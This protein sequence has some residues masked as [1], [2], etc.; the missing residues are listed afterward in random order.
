[1][2]EMVQLELLAPARDL[3]CGMA[4]INCGADAVYIGAPKFGARSA[5]GNSLDNLAKLVNYAHKYSARVYTTVNTI[6]YDNELEDARSLIIT[7]HDAGIDA[8]IIQDMA[9][10]EMDLPPVPLFASTQ[11]DNRLPEKIKFLEQAGI[12]RVILARE[13]SL[14]QIKKIRTAANVELEAFIHGALCVSY[15]G[16]CYISHAVSSRSANR[17]ECIQA[18]RMQYS[19][20]DS[21]NKTVI[22][23]KYLLSL[24]DLNQTDHLS[25]LIDAGIT[26]FKIEGRLKDITY[27]KNITAWYRRKLDDIIESRPGFKKSSSGR[28]EIDFE[29]DPEKTFNRGY[30]SYFIKSGGKDIASFNTQKS[31]G[32]YL[33]RVRHLKDNSFE[34]D[35]PVSLN[36]GDGICFLNQN[37][38]LQGMYVNKTEKGRIYVRELRGLTEGAGIYRNFN[39]QF[40]KELNRDN[41]KRQIAARITVTENNENYILTA[42]DEDG[43]KAEYIFAHGGIPAE[44]MEKMKET[45]VKQ[46]SRSGD[47]L[48][49]INEVVL[50]VNNIYFIRTSV[51]N[52]ARRTLLKD[53]EGERIKNYKP[54]RIKREKTDHKFPAENLTYL[55]NSVNRLSETFYK[56]HGVEK[57][58]KGFELMNSRAGTV[59][60]KCKYCIKKELDI[61]PKDHKGRELN[62]WLEPLYITDNKNKFQ[63]VFDCARCE[64][65]VLYPEKIRK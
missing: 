47:S 11:T 53:L 60:M 33:G 17:G 58:D 51:L 42:E 4:A 34:L 21:L 41:A 20:V 39:H 30:T 49:F 15:S 25:D 6:L 13:L 56:N 52:E 62:D 2:N 29:P 10:L 12:S 5:A 31:T 46:L 1:M 8:V 16:Q 19:L 64:M 65:S 3:E 61:C 7:L 18:C 9:L 54:V 44:N 23:D 24:K 57:V 22:K 40:A 63:L 27:V 55:G 32:E 59:V 37:D 35:K 43:N 45:F 48:F 14:A 38:V 28:S 26:S 50:S 36:N